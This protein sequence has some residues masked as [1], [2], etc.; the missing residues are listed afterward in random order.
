MNLPFKSFALFALLLLSRVL[1]TGAE[2][3]VP[4]FTTL[5]ESVPTTNRVVTAA[6]YV[7]DDF[8]I[9]PARAVNS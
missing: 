7:P 1:E 4:E 9:V 8:V 5:P 3:L 6:G 2:A